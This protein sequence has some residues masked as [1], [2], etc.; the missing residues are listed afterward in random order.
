MDIG[1]FRTTEHGVD[2]RFLRRW[3]PRAM[4]G[5]LIEEETLLGLFEAARSGPS[6]S[7]CSPKVTGSG[8]FVPPF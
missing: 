5:E 6:S 2:E 7:T 1:A 4:S 3:S 8:Q